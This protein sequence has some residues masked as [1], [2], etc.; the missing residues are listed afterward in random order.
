MGDEIADGA[1][2]EEKKASS[3]CFLSSY[4]PF[5]ICLCSNSLPSLFLFVRTV[6]FADPRTSPPNNRAHQKKKITI[7]KKS[8][9]DKVKEDE[10]QPFLPECVLRVRSLSISM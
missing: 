2:R 6:V 7:I 1:F 4:Y 10:Q 5:V 8:I 9:K 3:P